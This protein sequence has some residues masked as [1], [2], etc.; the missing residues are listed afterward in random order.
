M[1]FRGMGRTAVGGAMGNL[2][3]P[4]TESAEDP[5]AKLTELKKLLDGGVI[6]QADFDTAKAKLLGL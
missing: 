3:Q 2:Q 4:V 6:T 5:Y 1:A